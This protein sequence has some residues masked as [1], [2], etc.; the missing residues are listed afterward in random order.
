MVVPAKALKQSSAEPEPATL[1]DGPPAVVLPV[2]VKTAF[3]C[4]VEVFQTPLI[5]QEAPPRLKVPW[6]LPVE[7]S[8]LVTTSLALRVVLEKVPTIGLLIIDWLFA[9]R[10]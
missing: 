7:S 10:F 3:G 8:A 6:N 5:G 2:N 1:L 9:S 4:M